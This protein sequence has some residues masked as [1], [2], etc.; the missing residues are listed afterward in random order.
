MQKHEIFALIRQEMNEHP[1]ITSFQLAEKYQ[2]PLHI[3]Q[4]VQNKIMKRDDIT[5]LK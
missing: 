2:I 3:V 4:I 5:P 1:D